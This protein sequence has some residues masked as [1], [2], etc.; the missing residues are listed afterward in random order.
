M[1]NALIICTFLAQLV[2]PCVAFERSIYDESTLRTATA[3]DLA[4]LKE[5]T[6][7][8][9]VWISLGQDALQQML[10]E[11]EAESY[12]QKTYYNGT[13]E[14]KAYALVGLHIRK[15][16]LYATL[17]ADF[18]RYEG[19]LAVLCKVKSLKSE[20]TPSA[21]VA[22]IESEDLPARVSFLKKK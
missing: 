12:L 17:K 5:R 1:R 3:F 11:K 9:G 18:I 13:S 21:I 15:S 7:P 19:K 10:R 4:S 16:S 6:R 2:S 20:E 22:A 14:A 8:D